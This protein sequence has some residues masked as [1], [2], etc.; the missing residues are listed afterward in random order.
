MPPDVRL[1]R[2]PPLGRELSSPRCTH[3]IPQQRGTLPPS[4]LLE[5]PEQRTVAARCA[6]HADALSQYAFAVVARIRVREGVSP[7]C[8]RRARRGE[9][10][11]LR[12]ADPLR[13]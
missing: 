3:A 1:S 6:R 5:R 2:S 7:G 10:S 11:R 4:L 9:R 12:G 13:E 8:E